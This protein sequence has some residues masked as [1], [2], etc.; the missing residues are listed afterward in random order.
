MAIPEA[1][2][3]VTLRFWISEM[4]YV[5][6]ALLET[7]DRYEQAKAD[8]DVKYGSGIGDVYVVGLQEMRSALGTLERASPSIVRD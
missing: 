8:A 4:I 5:R 7:I 6:G 2:N 1:D 3:P